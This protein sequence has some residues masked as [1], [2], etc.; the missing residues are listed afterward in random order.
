MEHPYP[1]WTTPA[2]SLGI[3]PENNFYEFQLAA[4][5]QG[6]GALTY[7]HISGTLPPGIHL[8]PAG[9]LEGVPVVVDA[10]TPS[11]RDYSFTIRAKNQYLNVADRTFSITVSNI[12]PP[13][14]TPRTTN[15]GDYFDGSFFSLQLHA[16]EVDPN[17]T[18]TWTLLNGTLP[19]G[20][21]LS[22]SGLLSGFL[23][24]VPTVGA[25]GLTNYDNT[26]YNDFGY[27]NA[28][29]YRTQNYSF[30]ISVNDGA[31]TDSLNYK[32][33][34]TAK[35]TWTA[36]DNIDTVDDSL[37]ID[38][39]NIYLPIVTTP[40]GSLPTL[41]CGSNFAFQFKAIDPN[42]DSVSFQLTNPGTSPFDENGIDNQT[43]TGGHWVFSGGGLAI[44]AGGTTPGTGF[45]STAFDQEALSL[46]AG[47]TLD[48][49][50][51]WFSGHLPLQTESSITYSFIV[52]V[53]KTDRPLYVSLPQIYYLT[54]IGDINNTITWTTPSD[55]GTIDNGAVSELSI[56]A[57]SQT[58]K[59]LIYT[60]A[61]PSN[62]NKKDYGIRDSSIV[63]KLPQGLKLLPSG[64]IS[65]RASF[66]YFSLDA[67]T[68][69]IDG[70]KSTFDDTYKFTV[71]AEASDKSVSSTKTFTIQLKNYNLK[72][73]ENLYLK[74]LPTLDQRQTFLDIVNNKD[75][76]PD[77]LIYRSDDPW[78]GRARDIRSLFLPG[79]EPSMLAD[80]AAA[81][82][83][84]H[85]NKRIEFGDVRT[86]RAV[87]ANFNVKYEVVYIPLLDNET[88][89]GNSP[90]NISKVNYGINYTN[91]SST[92]F[93]ANVYPN[94]FQNMQS[95]ISSH[96]GYANQGALPDWMSS[97]QT[98]KKV[99]GFTRAIVLAYTVPGASSLIAYRLKANGIEFNNIDFVADRY[100]LDNT[101][102]SHFDINRGKFKVST[103]TT[104][105]RIYRVGAVSHVVDYAISILPFNRVNNQTL[106]S[107][108]AVGGFDGVLNITDGQTLIFYQQENFF[109]AGA[110]DGWTLPNSSVIPGYLENLA[111]PSVPNER[112]GIWRINID[113][114]TNI[115]TLTFVTPVTIS[116][117]IQVNLGKTHASSILYYNPVVQPGQTV[118][119]YS[120]VLHTNTAKPTVFDN[121][122]TVFLTNRDQYG[123]PEVGD[124]YL[125]FPKTQVLQ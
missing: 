109:N 114:T 72:P 92:G 42:G 89:K 102:S 96:L 65:G 28:P 8:T 125:K 104:F 41:R 49:N 97:P 52:Q 106:D 17:A 99:L 7:S 84:N 107:I 108:Q 100:D 74:A 112:G 90:A 121:H 91:G 26:A 38:H 81:M 22:P 76:F 79:I 93:S 9:L 88:Y 40:P 33:K 110:N 113:P 48:S 12:L 6:T 29:L 68:T 23:Y 78:F 44:N 75:I 62:Q 54:V 31:N 71:L 45:D 98:D 50:T 115:V 80:Y 36:D 56:S 10:T 2:G 86:A 20:I 67:G 15:L 46:P 5:S 85:F 35:G 1:I 47:L 120:L 37:T 55:L 51:G 83:T 27:D 61:P 70:N 4:N 122:A 43:L 16:T 60:L 25:A 117:Q 73:Y 11:N 95:A 119:A 34:V 18:L 21:S 82:G 59:D 13:Q 101:Y 69:T 111:N 58:G 24:P 105:D 77:N 118:P 32:L 124:T 87:D 39:D 94:S 116:S 64:L 53:Y 57:V 3:L 66:E 14:I 30:T 123:K 19:N 63:S 103:E